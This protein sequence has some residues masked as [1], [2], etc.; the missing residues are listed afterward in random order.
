MKKAFLIIASLLVLISCKK[1][2]TTPEDSILGN[3]TMTAYIHDGMDVYGTAIL[4]CFTD[5]II[6]F[7]NND[8][9]TAD[10]GPTKCDSSDPQTLAGSYTFDATSK[11]LTVTYNGSTETDDVR[12]LNSTTLKIEQQSNGDMITYTRVP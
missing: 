8:Q 9:I 11:L 7:K 1:R 3:W 6:T 4:P 12:V 10:E 5:N 2:D